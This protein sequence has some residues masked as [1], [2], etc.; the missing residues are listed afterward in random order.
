MSDVR[1]GN[2]VRMLRLMLQL[3]REERNVSRDIKAFVGGLSVSELED[4]DDN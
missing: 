1:K 3:W 2:N 4:S